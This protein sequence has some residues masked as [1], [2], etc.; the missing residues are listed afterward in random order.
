MDVCIDKVSGSFQN[1]RIHAYPSYKCFFHRSFHSRE[2][3]GDGVFIE[4]TK[5]YG[6]GIISKSRGWGRKDKVKEEGFLSSSEAS[7]LSRKFGR[8]L[9]YK[10]VKVGENWRPCPMCDREQEYMIIRHL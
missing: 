3:H 1:K 6:E 10:P 5:V 9:K 2:V 8:S 7:P 4:G